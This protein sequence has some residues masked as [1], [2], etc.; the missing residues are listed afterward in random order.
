V[1]AEHKHLSTCFQSK[2]TVRVSSHTYRQG[3]SVG[4]KGA[5]PY[6]FVDIHQIFGKIDTNSKFV[7]CM[8]PVE[9]ETE[10]VSGFSE[11]S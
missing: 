8:T 10:K 3:S 1:I 9:A 2:C 6:F 11:L 5:A 7:V 4:K